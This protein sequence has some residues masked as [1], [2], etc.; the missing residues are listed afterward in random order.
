M[1]RLVGRKLLL[2]VLGPALLAP[3]ALAHANAPQASVK[4]PSE[5]R[6]TATAVNLSGVGRFRTEQLEI[7]IDRWSS[8]EERDRLMDMLK[9]KGSD[10]ALAALQQVKPRAGYI[11]T[12]TRLGWD[13]QFAGED[14]LPDGGRRIVFATDRPIG[15]FEAWNRPR[16]SD[17]GYMVCWIRLD[18]NGS[19]D[20][21]LSVL[22][23]VSYDEARKKIVVEDY[24]IEPV[25]L[26]RVDV[27]KR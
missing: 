27:E 7:V 18:K 15:F 25:R 9:G 20:G 13:L 26:T 12:T 19:G 22:A 3:A 11:R 16:S 6:L 10:Q 5:L 8:D 2:A 17:Y 23:Q 14:A 1:E 4:N 21:K 24:G